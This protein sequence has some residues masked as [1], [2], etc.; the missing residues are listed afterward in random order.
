MPPF[1]S[2]NNGPANGPPSSVTIVATGGGSNQTTTEAISS[3]ASAAPTLLPGQPSNVNPKDTGN[4]A[5]IT[6]GAQTYK[7]PTTDTTTQYVFAEANVT[8]QY[9]TIVLPHTNFVSDAKC[10]ANGLQLVFADSAAY[11]FVKK[12]WVVPK[13]GLILVTWSLHCN[14]A[15]D[16]LHVY[17]QVMSFAFNDATM[18][19]TVVAQE[20]AIENALHE[21]SPKKM[22][23][24][25][26][27]D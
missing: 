1:S 5:P 22:V 2:T 9:P 8:Y 12:N 25:D 13:Q 14:A 3:A 7:E 4:L 6:S 16:G 10:T 19:V 23:K 17:W 21:V 26:G 24:T 11:A 27:A 18:T 15:D 20:V